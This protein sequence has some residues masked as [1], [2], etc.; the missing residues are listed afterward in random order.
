MQENFANLAKFARISCTR[1]F[2][3][4]QYVIEVEI[5]KSTE[6]AA[7]RLHIIMT[8]SLLG[9]PPVLRVLAMFE[10]KSMNTQPIKNLID[11]SF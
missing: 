1:I 4:I 11:P 3:V 6:N 9:P 10:A 7:L 5:I 2:P 8:N